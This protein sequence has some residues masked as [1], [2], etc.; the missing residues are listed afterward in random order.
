MRALEQRPQ[1][2]QVHLNPRRIF[3]IFTGTNDIGSL[4]LVRFQ[5]ISQYTQRISS[6]TR[7]PFTAHSEDFIPASHLTPP[8]P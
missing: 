4:C 1:A 3:P 7:T 8:R 5:I 2:R 6:H